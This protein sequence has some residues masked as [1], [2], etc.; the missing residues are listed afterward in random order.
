[1]TD[2]RKEV[3]VRRVDEL[4]SLEEVFAHALPAFGGAFLR[5]AFSILDA[6]TCR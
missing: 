3:H 1:M 5:R 6:A 4:S 2:D